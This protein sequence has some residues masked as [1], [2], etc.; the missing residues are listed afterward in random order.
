MRIGDYGGPAKDA[1]K[2]RSRGVRRPDRA[3]AER[4]GRAASLAAG[5]AFRLQVQELADRVRA[6]P[7]VR[8][9]V[10]EE[11]QRLLEGGELDTPQ[12]YHDAAAALLKQI[13]A[14]GVTTDPG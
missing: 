4:S 1:G 3:S 6:M 8:G 10:V 12:A 11:A 14:Y 7:E 9:D 2:V 5:D 13:A